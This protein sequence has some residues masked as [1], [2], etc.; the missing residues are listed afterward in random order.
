MTDQARTVPTDTIT[1]ERLALWRKRFA[2]DDATP[3]LLLGVGHNRN[4][5]ALVVCTLEDK[6]MSKAD[7]L[8]FLYG[9]ICALER[10]L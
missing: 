4:S 1:A 9:A 10:G 3:I 2:D 8:K 5:G 7:L 6:D